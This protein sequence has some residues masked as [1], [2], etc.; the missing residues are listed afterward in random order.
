MGAA[1][2]IAIAAGGTAGHVVPALAIA[3]ALTA[4][5]ASVFFIGGVRAERDLVLAAGY[6]LE[7]IDVRGLD[8]R[9]ALK[10][11]AALARSAIATARARALLRTHDATA[12]LGAGGYVAAPV[13]LAAVA[14]RLPL[15][16][17]EAD[18]RLGLS[19]RL[20][21]P[22]ARRVCLAFPIAG[23]D[24]P[25]YLVTGRAVAPP[26]ADRVTARRQYALG[27]DELMV[28]V[29]GGSLGAHSINE[30]ALAGLDGA[31]FRVLHVTGRRDWP[32]FRAR[33]HT[34]GY[35]LREYL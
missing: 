18:S 13:G 33:S 3:G 22:L 5:Q 10:A 15:V 34:S 16:L 4:Q 31:A 24:D 27:E 1:P 32:A 28:F 23:R 30:A 35:E 20:L 8:R 14:L 9:N 25:R 19:N 12:V 7:Q 6:E 11:S 29:F 17:C 2:R 26:R 21:A